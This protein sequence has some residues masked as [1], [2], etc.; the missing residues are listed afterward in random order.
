MYLEISANK[1][2]LI[3]LVKHY[4]KD[5]VT[6]KITEWVGNYAIHGGKIATKDKINRWAKSLGYTVKEVLEPEDYDESVRV[7]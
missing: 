1:K 5:E 2:R 7:S 4:P 6:G 3:D